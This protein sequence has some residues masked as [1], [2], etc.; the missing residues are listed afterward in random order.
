MLSASSL[1]AK[2]GDGLKAAGK[3]L[4]KT[5]KKEIK[6]DRNYLQKQVGKCKLNK[7]KEEDVKNLQMAKQ[8]LEISAQSIL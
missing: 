3:Q 8:K 6:G 7:L 4:D 5:K 2:T 1:L